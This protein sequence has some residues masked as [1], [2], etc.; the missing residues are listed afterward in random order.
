MRWLL[1]LTTLA[2]LALLLGG[3]SVS[4]RAQ[5]PLTIN[6]V[7]VEGG[8]ATLIVTPAGESILIDCGDQGPRDAGRIAAAAKQLGLSAIDH[9]ITTHWHS[10][11]YGGAK[12]L[13]ELIPIRRYY[14][15]GLDP[16]PRDA[17]SAPNL[18]AAYR[19]ASQG[20]RRVLKAG[21]VLR[22]KPARGARPVSLHCIVGSRKTVADRPDAPINPVASEHVAKEEDPSDNADSL[23]FVLKFGEFRFLDLGDLTWNIEH[24]L[25][26]PTD[27]IGPID[28]Y[29]TTH[30]G[31]D[32]SNNPVVIRTVKPRVAIFNNGARKGG[33]V[34]V[35]HTLRSLAE[36]AVIFQVHRNEGATA[37]EQAP[38][39]RIANQN[40]AGDQAEG[41]T[42]TVAPDGASYTVRVG[43][44]GQPES[45][46]TRR[47]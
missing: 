24:K 26:S 44:S 39:N 32:V 27:K 21:D 23:G 15:R 41:I 20:K 10:D 14:D 18:V 29:Q 37:A 3:G 38:A 5:K 25:V 33:A 46:R 16:L 28:V 22:F 35:I 36:P 40:S 7:D 17:A 2:T 1:T 12:P 30:H 19:A 9:L 31:L 34:S 47:K 13:S 6:Y 8:A 45:F 11:H 4:A 42:V 43:K